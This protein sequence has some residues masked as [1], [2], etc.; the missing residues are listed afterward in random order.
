MKEG[1]SGF[2]ELLG[3]PGDPL[4][5]PVLEV[6]AKYGSV[7]EINT[8]ASNAG[9]LE[10]LLSRLEEKGT[11]QMD[12]LEWLMRQK[13]EGRFISIEEYRRE[14][15]GSRAAA[16]KFNDDNAVTLEISPLQYFPWLMR[17]ARQAVEKREIMPGRFIRLRRMREQEADGDILAVHAAMKILGASCVEQPETSGADGSN[18]HLG[19]PGTIAGYYGGIGAPN[20]Y[21]IKWLEEVLYYYTSY[22]IREFINVNYGTMLLAMIVNA[23]GIDVG[24]KISVTMGHDNPYQIYWTLKTAKMFQR[25]DGATA[26]VGM[27]FSNSVNSETIFAASRIRKELGLEK[28]VRFEHHIT[29]PWIGMVRQPYLRRE[30]LLEIAREVPNISAKHEGGEPDVEE[31]RSHPSNHQENFRSMEEVLSSGDMEHM[32][33]NYMDKHDSVNLTARALTQEGIS[34]VGAV[35]LHG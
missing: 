18:I 12:G 3:T 17:Q 20:D 7:E 4:M 35:N 14:V 9:K 21:P 23:L 25:D 31:K 16:I 30:Q 28:S 13:E 24:I 22:G 6:I 32:E 11:A 26:L 19:G 1:L 27:N 8:L 33:L 29:E 34:F 15:L 2:D 10:N 5:K